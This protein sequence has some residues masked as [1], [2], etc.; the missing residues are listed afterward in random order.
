M[1][2]LIVGLN[3]QEADDFIKKTALRN[4]AGVPL[5][6]ENVS[7]QRVVLQNNVPLTL[8]GRND[9]VITIIS[10]AK[11]V[12][13][14]ARLGTV[15]V[16]FPESITPLILSGPVTNIAITSLNVEPVDVFLLQG[17]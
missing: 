7:S 8:P 10:P 3:I 6:K 5:P 14:T 11:P 1:K 16:E 4:I 17:A 2:T 15:S 12:K 13:V 9:S